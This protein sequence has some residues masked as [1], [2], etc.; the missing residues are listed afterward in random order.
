MRQHALTEFDIEMTLNRMRD[1]DIAEELSA[2][3]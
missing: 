1:Q 3:S 2:I